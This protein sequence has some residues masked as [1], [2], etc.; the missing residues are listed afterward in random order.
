MGPPGKKTM[1]SVAARV[2]DALDKGENPLSEEEM[3]FIW[4]FCQIMKINKKQKIRVHRR[5]AV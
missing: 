1:G 4:T 2:L 5:T 3:H